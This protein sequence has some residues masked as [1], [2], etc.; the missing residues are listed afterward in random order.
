MSLA[1]GRARLAAASAVDAPDPPGAAPEEDLRHRLRWILLARLVAVSALLLTLALLQYA[2]SPLR[3]ERSLPFLQTLGGGTYLATLLYAI[4][5][6][7]RWHPRAIAGVNLAGDVALVTALLYV[8]GGI[9][10][11]FTFLYLPGILVG[12]VLFYRR[13][14]FGV[15][16]GA[17]VAYGALLLAQATGTVRVPALFVNPVWPTAP[18]E[19]VAGFFFNTAVFS[20]FALLCGY[21]AEQLRATGARLREKEGDLRRLQAL[22]LEIVSS[23]G[24]GVLTVDRS[25]HV[26]FLNPMGERI[27]GQPIDRAK[28]R[29]LADLL[30][31]LA[32]ASLSSRRIEVRH[33]RPDGS[34]LDLGCSFSDLGGEPGGRI[35]IFQDLT[36]V[37]AAE[38]HARINERLAAVGRLSAGIAHEIRNPL[39]SIRGS[40]EILAKDLSL[41]GDQARL[42]TIVLRETDRL[43]HLITDFLQFARPSDIKRQPVPLADLLLDTLEAFLRPD[44]GAPSVEARLE[45]PAGLVAEGDPARIRQIVWNLLINARDAM[46]GGGRLL[47]SARAIRP[48]TPGETPA[49]RSGGAGSPQGSGGA[50]RKGE[51]GE[52][53]SHWVEL[54][55]EDSGTGIPPEV[56]PRIFEPF[57]TTKERG[58]G[59]GLATV[60]RIVESHG[61]AIEVASKPGRGTVF[62][63]R[64]PLYAL[65]EPGAPGAAHSGSV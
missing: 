41:E 48:E 24:S 31:S 1:E 3:L 40:I 37:K 49:D 39:A 47:V 26:T 52:G 35:L 8:T 54:R 15:A 19:V 18:G 2:R 14:A 21:L 33:A 16:M 50:G 56:L 61:G 65:F 64:L 12:A 13:G 17:S 10:S 57:Y 59:L 6:W 22:T 30:P 7:R 42:M 53:P 9:D 45:V 23:M 43:N 20:V 63:V 58:T 25:D 29:P 44:G 28:G 34:S 11:G 27:T 36:E 38:E 46:P 60:H 4:A 55:F 32:G 62:T 51:G 5:L